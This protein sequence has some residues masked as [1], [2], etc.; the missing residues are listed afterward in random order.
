MI[1]RRRL[2]PHG[3]PAQE[4]NR[5]ST[6]ST[7]NVTVRPAD[8]RS[9]ACETTLC[10]PRDM[11]RATNGHDIAVGLV[12]T[13][14]RAGAAAGRLALL[15]VRLAARAPV[16]GP[17]LRRAGEGLSSDGL[18]ARARSRVQL[19]AAADELLA[20]P[21]VERTVDRAM[22]GPLTDT[23]AHSLAKHRVA[24][25][26]AAEIAATP[27]FEQAVADALDHEATQRLVDRALASAGLER[28][29]IEALE[30]RL[31]AE[32]T[33]RVLNSP[34]MQRVVEHVAS[35]PAVRSALQ[36]QTTT[37]VEE[38]V[39]GLR[40]R[41]EGVDEAAQRRIRRRQVAD[42]P[43]AGIA[44]RAVGLAIDVLLAHIIFLTGAA[45]VG[46]VASLVGDLRPAWLVAALAGAGWTLVV[47]T[48]FVLFWTAAGQTPGM[49]LMRL[50]VS[51]HRGRPPSLGRSVVRFFG[52][53]LAIVPLF[54]GF[55]PVLVDDRR[56][57]L[58]DFLAGTIVLYVDREPLI[59]E[60][61][62]ATEAGSAVAPLGDEPQHG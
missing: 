9:L 20:A 59:V 21:E 2:G 4:S 3:S 56:R 48:Y 37:L 16:V 31:T 33:D 17:V 52:L 29:V 47:G 11:T 61:A 49:R 62:S 58:H 54:A 60:A 44:T 25:R 57:G 45:L 10:D 23:F 50:R 41:A 14:V 6:P 1:A 35:S 38:L 13:G 26:V 34:E 43:Y 36:R 27:E 40:R 53:V 24:E 46:L 18:E 19:E 28:L 30:S 7:A 42:V 32:V 12:A 55:L 22:A 51:D 15:P 39:G 8:P 5:P